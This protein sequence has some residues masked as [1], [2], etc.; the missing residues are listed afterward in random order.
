MDS[1]GTQQSSLPPP[2]HKQR[3]RELKRL[4]ATK[5]P[6]TSVRWLEGLLGVAA[7]PSSLSDP[8]SHNGPHGLL[9]VSATLTHLSLTNCGLT[10]ESLN[11]RQ[12]VSTA[13]C[14]NEG[15]DETV[16]YNPPMEP[17]YTFDC[18]VFTAFS[19]VTFLDL[20]CNAL[21]APPRLLPPKL[22]TLKLSRNML[23]TLKFLEVMGRTLRCLDV[24]FNDASS[25]SYLWLKYWRR[26]I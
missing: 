11:T 6:V 1:L 2:R 3:R 14:D 12:L 4:S 13:E 21:V 7:P 16:Y 15:Y 8:S 22:R 19:E 25:R 23:S 26:W 10:N 5:C 18:A 9:P 20:S 17:Q 24:S